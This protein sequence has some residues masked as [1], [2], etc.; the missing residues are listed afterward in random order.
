[1]LYYGMLIQDDNADIHNFPP[2]PIYELEDEDFF[3]D[4][5]A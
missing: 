1:M 2:Y 3:E 4:I 5:V